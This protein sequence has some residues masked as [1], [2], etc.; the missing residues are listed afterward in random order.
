[1]LE[2]ADHLPPPDPE[3]IAGI[4]DLLTE[5]PPHR[6]DAHLARVLEQLYHGVRGRGWG[7]VAATEYMTKFGN[8]LLEAIRAGSLSGAPESRTLQ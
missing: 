5:L 4:A 3:V 8:Q 6:L 7:H 2:T 1:M